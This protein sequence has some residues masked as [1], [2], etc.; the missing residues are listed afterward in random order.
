MTPQEAAYRVMFEVVETLAQCGEFVL[1]GGWV[2][3]LHFPGQGH[4]GSIDVDL[5]LPPNGLRQNVDLDQHLVDHGYQRSQRPNPTQYL[6]QLPQTT[7]PVAIDLLTTPRFQGRDVMKIEIGGVSVESLPGLDLALLCNE[8]RTLRLESNPGVVEE[9]SV[10]VVKPEAFILIKA[11]PLARRNKAKDAYDIAFTLQ[12]YQP[13]LTQLAALIAPLIHTKSGAEAYELLQES[14][15]ELDSEGPQQAASLANELG[16]SPAQM[17]Q[18][19]FQDA[20]ALF[21][22]I[23][24]V[25]GEL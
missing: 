17:Q 14:F 20:Q 19:A 12:H 24:L 5:V 8:H 15:A 3:E 4:V 22:A 16:Q 11:F 23:R 1:V 7:T 13:S 25:S 18:A 10:K 2:P 21:Q 9:I 6:R